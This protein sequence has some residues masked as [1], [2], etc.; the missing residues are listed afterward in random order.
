[1]AA[2]LHTA[3]GESTQVAPTGSQTGQKAVQQ[4]VAKQCESCATEPGQL[5]HQAV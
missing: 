2:V 3:E 1:M 4:N 5:Q